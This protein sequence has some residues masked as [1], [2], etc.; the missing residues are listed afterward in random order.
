MT[1]L[2]LD[3]TYDSSIESF[4]STLKFF[5][6]PTISFTTAATI[7]VLP[8]IVSP[9]S[10][11]ILFTWSPFLSVIVSPTVCSQLRCQNDPFKHDPVHVIALCKIFLYHL[12]VS[13]GIK[14]KVLICASSARMIISHLIFYYSFPHSLPSSCTG[15]E[16]VPLTGQVYFCFR[17]FAPDILPGIFPLNSCK[18]CSLIMYRYLNITFFFKF[19]S[20]HLLKPATTL[21]L[22]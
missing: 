9:R 11:G 20:Y 15:L 1:F 19:F 16:D 6:N 17:A 4:G 5:Q 14:V 8:N 3:P 22:T 7:L 2:F 13:F 12:P 18:T 21:F 10:T